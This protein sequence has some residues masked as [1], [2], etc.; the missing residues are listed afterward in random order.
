MTG[1]ASVVTTTA[2]TSWWCRRRPSAAPPPTPRCRCPGR[3]T[4]TRPV[5]VGLVT[6]QGSESSPAS[7]PASRSSRHHRHRHRRHQP[8]PAGWRAVR[9]R[10]WWRFS[11][12]RRRL[13][14]R[15]WRWWRRGW[16]QP[17]IGE[18]IRLAAGRLRANALRSLLTVVGLVIGVG[19]VVTLVA[20]G[21]GSAA[22]VND[23]FSRL[24][25][26]TMT[27]MGAAASAAALSGRPVEP[28]PHPAVWR[29]SAAGLGPAGPRWCRPRDDHQRR[30]HRPATVKAPPPPST[31]RQPAAGR[32]AFFSSF[33]EGR[34][35]K[36]AV[37]GP[38][39]RR[40]RPDAARQSGAP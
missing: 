6:T 12:R 8:E 33:A 37:L 14:R 30:D 27:V 32:R 28:D 9:P 10:R 11:R 20:V 31:R 35:L 16:R 38:P 17:M 2:A 36:L 34:G 18:A 4:V 29:P 23:Q 5:V 1:Q 3:A 24:G 26:N 13:P 21:N 39:G 40:P 7:T 19:S 25:S 22:D 15:R